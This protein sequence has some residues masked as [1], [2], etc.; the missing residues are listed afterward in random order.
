MASTP[1]AAPSRL[2]VLLAAAFLCLLIYPPLTSADIIV[3]DSNATLTHYLCNAADTLQPN[4]TM[5]LKSGVYVLEDGPMCRIENLTD[6]TIRGT[7]DQSEQTVIACRGGDDATLRGIAFS[8]VT[9]LRIENLRIEDCGTE[10]PNDLPEITYST[11]VLFG[12]GQKAVLL[13]THCLNLYLEEVTLDRCYGVAIVGINVMGTVE[14]NQVTIQNTDNFRHPLCNEIP[15]DLSCSGSGAAFVY[16]DNN[17][18]ETLG[19][20]VTLSV[21]RSLFVNNTNIVPLSPFL[22]LYISVRAA[23]RSDPVL[24]TGAS[25]LGVYSSQKYYSVDFNM[26]STTV[27]NCGG[28]VGGVVLFNYNT[29][30][31]TQ[32]RIENSIIKHNWLAQVVELRG[33]GL[34]LIFAIY[35]DHLGRFPAYPNSVYNLVSV[36]GTMF[37]GNAG[38]QGGGIYLHVTPQN[39]SE[40]SVTIKNSTFAKNEANVGSALAAAGISTTFVSKP[41]TVLLQDV[42]AYGNTFSEALQTLSNTVVRSSA[43][44]FVNIHNVTVT[45]RSG[46]GSKFYSNTPHGVFVI[47]GANMLLS[48]YVTFEDNTAFNGGALSLYDNSKLYIHEGST[49]HF[50]RNRAVQRGGAIYGNA[51]GTGIADACMIQ[52]IGPSLIFDP[53]EADVLNLTLIF[54]NNTAGES[55]N[56]FYGNPIYNCVYLPESSVQHSGLF[57]S[58][59]RLYKVIFDFQS[60]VDNGIEELNSIPQ[61]LCYCED[62]TKLFEERCNNTSRIQSIQTIPG[63][64]FTVNIIPVDAAGTPVS[65][66]IYA[67]IQ[68][69]N[70]D[71][72]LSFG[73]AQSIRRHRGLGCSAVNFALYGTEDTTAVVNLY[74]SQ[75]D[76]PVVINVTIDSCP[77]GFTLEP[78]SDGLLYCT[79]DEFIT[80]TIRTTCNETSH[81]IKRPDNTWIGLHGPLGENNEVVFVSTCPI[82]YCNE[83]VTNIDLLIEDQLCDIGRSGILCGNCNSPL[84]VIFGSAKCE[85]CSSLWLLTIPLYMIAGVLLVLLIFTLNLTVTKG[86]IIGLVFYVNIVSVNAN[87]F[88]RGVDRG[89]LFVFISLLN[90]ELGFPVCFYDGMSEIAKSGFQFIFPAYLLV[91][92]GV[93]IYLSRWSSRMQK[94]TSCSGVAVLATLIYLS[95]SKILR[96]VI[97]IL[98][99][100]TL[101]TSSNENHLIWLYDGNVDYFKGLHIFLAAVAVVVILVLIIPYTLSLA[102]IVLIQRKSRRLRLKP[103][104][105]VYV[106]T[107]K[108]KWRFWFGVRLLVLAIMCILYA[109]LGTDDPRLSLLFQLF[110]IVAFAIFQSYI[111][112]Y[113]SLAIEFLDMSFIMNFIILALASNHIIDDTKKDEQQKDV[114]GVMLSIAFIVFLGIIAYHMLITLRK[115]ERFRQRTD[116]LLKDVMEGLRLGKYTPD[117]I[118]TNTLAPQVVITKVEPEVSMMELN[119]SQPY[120]GELPRASGGSTSERSTDSTQGIT[121]HSHISFETSQLT[122]EGFRPQTVTFSKLREPILDFV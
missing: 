65:S 18:T 14:L 40:F 76:S 31:K 69:T 5:Q 85:N 51:L 113:R 122:P 47:A 37:Y 96:T 74:T 33:A 17:Y 50:S 26:A 73:P 11:F 30:M 3:M 95:Y 93:I 46:Y 2:A 88:F 48:G 59:S 83:Y 112:P 109:A 117:T 10:I 108:D 58:A 60:T 82:D 52:I 38:D 22:Q 111:Q 7:G 19:E 101:N 110:V 20:N 32:Y 53:S 27:E 75:A 107:F 121:S 54:A 4:T 28:V 115:N 114:V 106:A 57:D 41:V 24:F 34:L 105:D 63:K 23:F 119:V 64:T 44:V 91:L 104:I 25:G 6:L 61:A 36:Q 45:G 102:L 116:E 100:A 21:S 72:E 62:E 13:F 87:I 29:V 49:I 81:T 39:V 16:S 56:S 78:N 120:T 103:L 92:C 118:K 79:C 71:D 35:L 70:K 86:T 66:L 1:K 68:T 55:G 43:F 94:I 67:E 97:D 84:S 80:D 8:N 77:P 89:F 12:P 90:L 9:N 98:T 99:F 42:E 15:E